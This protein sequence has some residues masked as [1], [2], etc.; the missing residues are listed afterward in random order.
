[1]FDLH[2]QRTRIH[3]TPQQWL[4]CHMGLCKFELAINRRISHPH[5][6]IKAPPFCQHPLL[7]TLK[8]AEIQWRVFIGAW[9]GSYR[10]FPLN[11]F[12]TS[13]HRPTP[14][15]KAIKFVHCP[16]FPPPPPPL[17][18][19][20]PSSLNSPSDDP[21]CSAAA[22][23]AFAGTTRKSRSNRH[24]LKARQLNWDLSSRG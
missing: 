12:L 15:G 18:L 2:A 24:E 14:A 9:G 1:M 23:L 20:L 16:Y 7:L 6:R 3:F 19:P 4:L 21:G 11:P 8:A 13:F 10:D 17:P 22:P 5:G